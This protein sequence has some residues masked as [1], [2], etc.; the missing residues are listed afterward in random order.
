MQC[1]WTPCNLK[2]EIDDATLPWTWASDSFDFVHIRYLL[3]AIR[4]WTAMFMQAYRCC[5]PGAWVQSAEVDGI[6]LSDDGTVDAHPV[7]AKWNEMFREASRKTGRSFMVVT[8]DLQEKGI[9][10]AGFTD[11]SVVNM[12][13]K[14]KV[15]YPWR[16]LEA[17]YPCS[18]RWEAGPGT[19]D[20][21][22]PVDSL[23]WHLKGTWKV[24]VCPSL[25]GAGMNLC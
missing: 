3:G 11:I 7:F 14:K 16:L 8:D 18:F 9:R 12:K 24:G 5:K 1:S 17:D 25:F 10:D 15:Y 2:F 20:S 21:R 19:S 22:K 6:F 4:D 23:S 13:V